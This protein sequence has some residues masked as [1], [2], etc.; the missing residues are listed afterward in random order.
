MLRAAAASA[1]LPS[2]VQRARLDL[3]P[4]RQGRHRVQRAERL[5]VTRI[6]GLSSGWR[7]GRA[8]VA[9]CTMAAAGRS[10][11]KAGGGSGAADGRV[12]FVGVTVSVDDGSGGLSLRHTD[13]VL[14]ILPAEERVTATAAAEHAR[15]GSRAA[16]ARNGWHHLQV[17]KSDGDAVIIDAVLHECTEHCRLNDCCQAFNAGEPPF[18]A[19]STPTAVEGT[20]NLLVRSPI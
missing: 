2:S 16:K 19:A 1:V 14:Q 9:R 7:G 5:V 18:E 11:T 13:T 4:T 6:A 10:V 8:E 15:V 3:R 17:I 20:P 12:T